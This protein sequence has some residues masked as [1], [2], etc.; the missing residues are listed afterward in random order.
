[1]LGGPCSQHVTGNTSRQNQPQS[2][3]INN[4]YMARA[5]PCDIGWHGFVILE[6]RVYTIAKQQWQNNGRAPN[7]CFGILK[8]CRSIIYKNDAVAYW[9]LYKAYDNLKLISLKFDFV[10][11]MNLFQ[12]I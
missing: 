9:A 5:W 6:S 10:F 12:K 2:A 3:I 8:H 11:Y 1:M 4:Q 7:V